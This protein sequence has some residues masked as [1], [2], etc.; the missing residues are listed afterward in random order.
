MQRP[1]VVDVDEPLARVAIPLLKTQVAYGALQTVM[2]DANGARLGI[3]FVAIHRHLLDIA[4]AVVFLLAH[5]AD[6]RRTVGWGHDRKR[7]VRQ[8]RQSV[9]GLAKL[10]LCEQVAKAP[11]RCQVLDTEVRTA[12]PDQPIKSRAGGSRC[13]ELLG[14]RKASVCPDSGEKAAGPVVDSLTASAVEALH[15]VV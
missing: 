1:P 12:C 13:K 14:I 7:G 8:G 15:F 4:L 10:L 6:R 2:F 11:V 5:L 9:L 3:P